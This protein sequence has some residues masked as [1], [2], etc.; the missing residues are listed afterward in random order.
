MLSNGSKN[1]VRK[2]RRC[3]KSS[4]VATTFTRAM[5]LRLGRSLTRPCVRRTAVTAARKC[6]VFARRGVSPRKAAKLLRPKLRSQQTRPRFASTFG[7]SRASAL[8]IAREH[9]HPVSASKQPA[10][11]RAEALNIA[12]RV[13]D[14]TNEVVIL[15]EVAKSGREIPAADLSGIGKWT[16]SEIDPSKILTFPVLAIDTKP[17]RNNVQYSAESQKASIKK[18]VGTTFL[19]NSAGTNPAF[20]SADHTLQ[21]ASQVARIYKAQL[22]ETPAGETGTLVWVYTVRGASEQVDEFINKIESGILREVSIHVQVEGVNCSICGCSIY[23]CEK[24]HIPGVK[25]GKETCV[26][27]TVGPLTPLELSSVACPGSVNAHVMRD[28]DSTAYKALPLREALSHKAGG[29]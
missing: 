25:Y 4:A 10:F 29:N 23:D 20:G 11:I 22:V 24:A 6:P 3:S 9:R 28:D 18:W 14:R 26:L 7:P 5:V 12:K 2:P 19:F 13:T 17:T 8:T 27:Q 15:S 21:A 1:A 16:R